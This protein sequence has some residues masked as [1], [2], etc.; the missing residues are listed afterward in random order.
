MPKEKQLAYVVTHE[1]KGAKF[2]FFRGRGCII[3]KN[4]RKD[5][6]KSTDSTPIQDFDFEEVKNYF[7]KEHSMEAIDIHDKSKSDKIVQDAK[8][9]MDAEG[10]AD[11]KRARL[12]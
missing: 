1:Y 6:A 12:N 8:K 4:L 3:S 10:L 11:R 2:R 5:Y 9:E 7:V